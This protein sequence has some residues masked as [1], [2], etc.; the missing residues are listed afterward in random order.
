MDAIKTGE[1]AMSPMF[2]IAK[3]AT[4]GAH[5]KDVLPCLAVSTEIAI[6]PTSAFATLAGKASIATR[7][8]INI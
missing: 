5:A 2:A 7:V 8:S 6:R 3:W 4:T 1:N